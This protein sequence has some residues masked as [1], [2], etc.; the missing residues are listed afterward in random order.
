MSDVYEAFIAEVEALTIRADMP[1]VAVVGEL[2]RAVK[3]A[4][5][6]VDGEIRPV[7]ERAAV[8]TEETP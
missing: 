2:T 5:M 3:R 6:V 8:H 4:Q 1:A 7:S